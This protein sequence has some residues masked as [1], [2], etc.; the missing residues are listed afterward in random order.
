MEA[1]E[2]CMEVMEGLA[3]HKVIPI[4]AHCRGLALPFFSTQS[5]RETEQRRKIPLCVSAP[6]LLCD[7]ELTRHSSEQSLKPIRSTSLL[8][9][10][11]L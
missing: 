2:I 10:L 1:M 6:L 5:N 8:Q 4:E 9:G 7:E 11:C 3:V